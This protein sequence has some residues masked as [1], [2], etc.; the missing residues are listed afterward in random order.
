MAAN[1][2]DQWLRIKNAFRQA[3]ENAPA[4]PAAMIDWAADAGLYK[5]DERSARRRAAKDLA[6]AMRSEMTTDARGHEVRVN[7]AFETE[8][9]WLWD[10]RETISRTHVELHLARNRR[11]VYGEIKA[12]VC[13]AND[14]MD[15]HPDEPP[16]QYSLNFAADLADDGIPIPSLLDLDELLGPAPSGPADSPPSSGSSRPSSRP[17]DHASPPQDSSPN[18]D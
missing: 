2:K 6:E 10:Q 8:T 16:L 13:T 14:Y 18:A 17:S 9:G 7:L 3:H 11:Q 15:L 5:S 12:Q 4:S 1:K